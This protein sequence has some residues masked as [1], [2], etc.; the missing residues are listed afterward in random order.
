MSVKRFIGFQVLICTLVVSAAWASDSAYSP[1]IQKLLREA[2]TTEA[3]YGKNRPISFKTT[4]IGKLQGY[5]NYPDDGHIEIHIPP[6]ISPDYDDA[7]L[8]HE[9]IHV[10]LNARGFAGVIVNGQFE[11]YL[12]RNARALFGAAYT[13]EA[14][15]KSLDDT[16]VKLNFCFSDELID[17]ETAKRGF[18]PDLVLKEEMELRIRSLSSLHESFENRPEVEKHHQALGEFVFL[19]RLSRRPK[20]KVSMLTYENISGPKFGPDVEMLRDRLLDTFKGKQCNITKPEDCYR[21]TLEL[22]GA[23]FLKGVVL[24][25]KPKTWDPE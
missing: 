11:R 24:L 20:L 16:I 17:R 21:L 12:G 13:P 25:P 5:T 9:L 7:I 4:E 14:K 1:R 23:A 19:N 22:R 18:N 15:E 10:I 3:R 8:A 6:P 2:R